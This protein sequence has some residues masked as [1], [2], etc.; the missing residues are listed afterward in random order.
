ME[1]FLRS[2][3]NKSQCHNPLVIAEDEN[4]MR[5]ICTECKN[6]FVIRKDWRGVPENR[7]YQKV[8]RKDTLQG[9]T[10]LFYKYYAQFLKT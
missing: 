1:A 4:A 10:N 2:C 3:D 6:Q 8:F 5:V 9:N 7:Q